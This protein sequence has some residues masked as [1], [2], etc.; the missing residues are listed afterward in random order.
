MSRSRTKRGDKDY[1]L[2]DRLKHENRR[3]KRQI[4]QL[5]KVIDRLDLDRI[6]HVRELLEQ[7][8]EQEKVIAELKKE[9]AW[10]CYDCGKGTLRLRTLDRRDGTF[11]NRVCDTC[12][13][14]T[15]LKRY[16]KDV[17]KS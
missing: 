10:K 17:E 13:K 1:D 3:L 8:D 11:Y 4:S 6:A 7:H 2:N 5:R 15:R 14:R 16:S 9:E 12:N